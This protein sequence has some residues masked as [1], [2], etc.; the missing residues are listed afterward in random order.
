MY[1]KPIIMGGWLIV[2]VI[3]CNNYTSFK[4]KIKRL[5]AIVFAIVLKKYKT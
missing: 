1:E 5:L 2:F 4:I 3:D